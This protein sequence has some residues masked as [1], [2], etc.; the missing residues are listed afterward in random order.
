MD[1]Q[2]VAGRQSRLGK[3]PDNRRE[4]G[5]HDG[6]G[7][8][9]LYPLRQTVEPF[10]RRHDVFGERP[11]KAQM[12]RQLD[13]TT[14]P[15]V[16]SRTPAP[17]ASTTPTTIAAHDERTGQRR[18]QGAAANVGVHV[19]DTLRRACGRAPH[20]RAETPMAALHNGCSPRDHGCSMNALS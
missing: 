16:R 2:R 7:L 15:S 20:A 10:F 13:Q 5:M 1:K 18:G 6:H 3:Q 8:T 14:S 11:L 17:V 9:R 4:G 19:I 12:P